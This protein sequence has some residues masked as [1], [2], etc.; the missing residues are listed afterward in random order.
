M[1]FIS[2][3]AEKILACYTDSSLSSCI[4]KAQESDLEKGGEGSKG[5]KIIGHTKSGKPIY[6]TF[7]HSAHKSFTSEEHREAMKI[8]SELGNQSHGPSPTDPIKSKNERHRQEAEKHDEAAFDLSAP[9]YAA[10]RIHLDKQE[11]DLAKQLS[12]E[13]N[14]TKR[15][16][17]VKEL[18]ARH[19]DETGKGFTLADL[20]KIQSKHNS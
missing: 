7:G 18:A 11:K 5:G 2:H 12:K 8:H 17:I 4:N 15:S 6:D 3:Q 1:D 14:T 16:E 13:N 9:R 10:S 20:E 19:K